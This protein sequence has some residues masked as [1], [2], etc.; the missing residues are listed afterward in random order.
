MGEREANAIAKRAATIGTRIDEII[1]SGNYVCTPKDNIKTKNCLKAFLQWR[2]R[3]DVKT[4]RMMTRLTDESIGLTGE[5]DILWVEKNQL[6]DIKATNYVWPSQFFQLGAYQRL[7]VNAD[8]AAIL[9][10]DPENGVYEYITNEKLGL[11]MPDLVDAYE[12]AF[13]HYRYY[14]HIEQQLKGEQDGHS[15]ATEVSSNA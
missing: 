15:N 1:K 13:K 7:G 11:T 14:T 3:Y 4:I 10:L 6:I 9:K 5:P 12:S 2:E 8:S